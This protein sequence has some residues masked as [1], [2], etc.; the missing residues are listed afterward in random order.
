M[1]L[2]SGD[3]LYMSSRT[4]EGRGQIREGS[5]KG[6]KKGYRDRDRKKRWGGRKRER[7]RE[8]SKGTQL[9]YLSRTHFCGD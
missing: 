1:E 8:E 2:E 4:V 5:R 7:K 6:W 9:I 3:G